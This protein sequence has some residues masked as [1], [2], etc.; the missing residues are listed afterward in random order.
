MADVAP[1][2]SWPLRSQVHAIAPRP[3]ASARL[4]EAES[5]SPCL[6]VEG[7]RA[8]SVTLAS[9]TDPV[10][11]SLTLTMLPVASLV[12]DSIPPRASVC[13]ALTEIRAPTSSWV[14]V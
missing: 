12:A 14:S 10:I 9:V 6:G 2:I 4:W 7:P 3:S 8:P 1:S 11:A 13:V 5:V